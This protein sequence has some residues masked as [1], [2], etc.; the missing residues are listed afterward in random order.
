MEWESMTS[1]SGISEKPTEAFL[2][3]WLVGCSWNWKRF[4]LFLNINQAHIE[5]IARENPCSEDDAKLALLLEWLRTSLKA[6]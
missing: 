5:N 2:Y 6:S 3:S 1:K 4:G